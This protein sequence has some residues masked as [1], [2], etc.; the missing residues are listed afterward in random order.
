MNKNILT[1]I[2]SVIVSTSVVLLGG[3]FLTDNSQNLSGIPI[4]PDPS[5]GS[6]TTITATTTAKLILAGNGNRQ[7]FSISN[8][9]VYD[10]WVS[11]TTTNLVANKGLWIKASTT[12]I[13]SGDSLYTGNIY[14]IG[15]G[16]TTLS[17]LEI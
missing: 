3:L 8:V 9:G 10:V 11:A 2:I 13:F 17:I 7:L 16:T 12:Q 14:A 5:L 6:N 1:I 15:T 4:S